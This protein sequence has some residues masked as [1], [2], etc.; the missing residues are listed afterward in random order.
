MIT[1]PAVLYPVVAFVFAVVIGRLGTIIADHF[2]K[3]EML[4]QSHA[5]HLNAAH[6]GNAAMRVAKHG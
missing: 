5:N 1:I 4:L 3:D 2:R 6:T